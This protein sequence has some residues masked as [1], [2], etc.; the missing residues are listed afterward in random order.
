MPIE[1]TAVSA[2]DTENAPAAR[3]PA[4]NRGNAAAPPRSRTKENATPAVRPACNLANAV[5]VYTV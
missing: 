2:S 4:S 3:A 5:V 1:P